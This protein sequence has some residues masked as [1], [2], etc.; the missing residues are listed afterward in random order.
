[1]REFA[2]RLHERFWLASRQAAPDVHK[3]RLDLRH[4]LA[5]VKVLFLDGGHV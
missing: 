5:E 1:M 2:Q 4:E 3:V